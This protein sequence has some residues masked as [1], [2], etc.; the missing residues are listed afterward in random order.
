M[1]NTR[2]HVG[3][4]SNQHFNESCILHLITFQLLDLICIPSVISAG[5]FDVFLSHIFSSYS[6]I[7]SLINV[8]LSGDSF[9]HIFDASFQVSQLNVLE[10]QGIAIIRTRKGRTGIFTAFCTRLEHCGIAPSVPTFSV[11]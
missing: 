6:F 3:F 9:H 10:A 1:M 11:H 7:H 8:V 2:K 4:R 5:H